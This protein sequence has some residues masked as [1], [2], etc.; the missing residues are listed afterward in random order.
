MTDG[1]RYVCAAAL[2]V[3]DIHT[4]TIGDTAMAAVA[5]TVHTAG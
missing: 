3:N 1:Q 5:F 2:V 4:Y